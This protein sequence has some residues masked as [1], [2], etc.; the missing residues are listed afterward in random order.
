MFYWSYKNNYTKSQIETTLTIE[1]KIT[2]EVEDYKRLTKN[3]KLSLVV[4]IFISCINKNK[5]NKGNVLFVKMFAPS[6]GWGNLNVQ[7]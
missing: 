7:V 5:K 2:K 3:P 1:N 4:L 6:N